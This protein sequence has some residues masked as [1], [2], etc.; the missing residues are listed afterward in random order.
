MSA[1]S[2]QGADGLAAWATDA[3][4]TVAEAQFLDLL[5]I[6]SPGATA[7][8]TEVRGGQLFVTGPGPDVA[9][10]AARCFERGLRAHECAHWQVAEGGLGLALRLQLQLGGSTSRQVLDCAH[11]LAPVLR[12]R[13]KL[14]AA[15]EMQTVV[16][17]QRAKSLGAEHDDALAAELQLAETLLLQ[18][19]FEE[20]RAHQQ[21]VLEARIDT[22]GADHSS[23]AEAEQDLGAT[24]IAQGSL[25]RAE[26][27]LRHAVETRRRLHGADARLTLDAENGLAAVRW[28]QRDLAGALALQEHVVEASRRHAANEREL[29]TYE[30]NLAATLHMQGHLLE[31]KRI[32]ERVVQ[33]QS[34]IFGRKHPDAIGAQSNLAWT[35]RKLGELDRA[36][37]LAQEAADSSRELLGA[38]HPTTFAAEGALIQTLSAQGDE[39]S[40]RNMA[41]DGLA[42]LPTMS[43]SIGNAAARYAFLLSQLEAQ[44]AAAAAID[45]VHAS[46]LAWITGL[47]D[48]LPATSMAFRDALELCHADERRASLAHYIGFHA[49]WVRLCMLLAPRRLPQAMAPLHGMES[50]VDPSEPAAGCGHGNAQHAACG[51]VEGAT[52]SSATAPA[53][54]HVGRDDRQC[55]G[56]HCRP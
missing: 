32:Q 50:C 41:V 55:A 52:R 38:G 7:L 48:S 20:A 13:G 56:P 11:R 25:S 10:L 31:A 6:E 54:D 24:L 14:Q 1:H 5:A 36:R 4:L 51:V 26:E 16:L 18:G 28:A 30:G 42:R 43:T 33:A 21:H 9:S 47:L 19:H 3:A 27:L 15:R 53:P 8:L 22:L 2:G 35:L 23:T 12:I 49:S 46:K 40:L 37:D 34:R 45:S 39:D 17:A 44:C 29:L